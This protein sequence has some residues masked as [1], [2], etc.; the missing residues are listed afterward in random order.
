[1][2]YHLGDG[3]EIAHETKPIIRIERIASAKPKRVKVDKDAKWLRKQIECFTGFTP[4]GERRLRA[5]ARR[6][7][8]VKGDQA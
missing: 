1:M 2:W 4:Y 8:Q 6:L 7:E 5:I 3:V